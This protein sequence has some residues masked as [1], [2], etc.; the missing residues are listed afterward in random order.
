MSQYNDTAFILFGTKD[1]FQ[2]YAKYGFLQNDD[3]V[4]RRAINFAEINLNEIELIPQSQLNGLYRINIKDDSFIFVS[5]HR[6]AVDKSGR[7]GY[8]GSIIGFKNCRPKKISD[9]VNFQNDLTYQSGLFTIKDQTIDDLLFGIPTEEFRYDSP[10]KSNRKKMMIEL[11]LSRE[12]FLE[13]AFSEDLGKSH[14]KI[15]F[16]DELYVYN[17]AQDKSFDFVSYEQIVEEKVNLLKSDKLKLE[18]EINIASITIKNLNK[19]IQDAQANLTQTQKIE[20]NIRKVVG[21]FENKKALLESD[22]ELATKK[23]LELSIDIKKLVLEFENNKK[24][25]NDS[26]KSLN[27][28]QENL[29]SVTKQINNSSKVLTRILN[30][31]ETKSSLIETM[32]KEINLLKEEKT[33]FLSDIKALKKERQGLG[34]EIKISKNKK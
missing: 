10:I 13:K 11:T 14:D 19:N 28:L 5:V 25:V 16:T 8:Y 6:Y 9:V 27:T 15:F 23:Q 12:K 26:Q 22:I 17:S 20:K 7:K 34:R 3:E 24:N 1:G 21:N 33:K 30:D 32:I 4:F 31:I 2:I 18:D 29:K